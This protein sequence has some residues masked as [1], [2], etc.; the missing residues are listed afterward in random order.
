MDEERDDQPPDWRGLSKQLREMKERHE[1]SL[2]EDRKLIR[3]SRQALD[4]SIRLLD[5]LAKLPRLVD[6]ADDPK[7]TPP[8]NHDQ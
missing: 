1:R 6:N 7:D 3:E 5:R 4:D 2:R 8:D